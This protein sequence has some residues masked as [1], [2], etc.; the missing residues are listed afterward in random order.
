MRNERENAI[1]A[2]IEEAKKNVSLS[3]ILYN[4][5]QLV[6]SLWITVLTINLQ[7]VCSQLVTDFTCHQQAIVSHDGSS[8]AGNCFARI[9]AMFLSVNVLPVMKMTMLFH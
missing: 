7:E 9:W 6:A 5:L 3:L 4:L 8:K 2:A 1:L